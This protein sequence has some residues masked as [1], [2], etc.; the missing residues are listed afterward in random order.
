MQFN[1]EK[2]VRNTHLQEGQECRALSQKS[3]SSRHPGCTCQLL[4]LIA[5]SPGSE[6]PRAAGALS[7]RQGR[8]GQRLHLQKPVHL[9]A[10]VFHI[11]EERR[12]QRERGSGKSRVG[13]D[14]WWQKGLRAG[15]PSPQHTNNA[16]MGQRKTGLNGGV[17]DLVA[18]LPDL[19]F[20]H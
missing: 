2:H 12:S 17:G 10:A 15:Q 3:P 1:R 9:K 5:P 20:H 13:L 16:W 8:Q 7:E 4:L 19:G 18:W 6:N 11:W 14:T